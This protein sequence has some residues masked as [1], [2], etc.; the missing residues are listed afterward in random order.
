MNQ[1][2]QRVEVDTPFTDI[3]RLA[4][5]LA[6][7]DRVSVAERIGAQGIEDRQGGEMQDTC[8]VSE[9]ILCTPLA[10]IGVG[11]IDIALVNSAVRTGP[12]V[13][14][15]V[16]ADG[17]CVMEDIVRMDTQRETVYTVAAV[18]VLQNPSV[19]TRYGDRIGVASEYACFDIRV[20]PE[21][22]R[23]LHVD[24]RLGVTC[25][26]ARPYLQMK[27]DDT[28]TSADRRHCVAV[29]AR[30]L[31]VSLR[32]RCAVEG[33]YHGR[34]SGANRIVEMRLIRTVE[35]HVQ[36]MENTIGREGDNERITIGE[37]SRVFVFRR[38]VLSY[39]PVCP[40]MGKCRIDRRASVHR[41]AVKI[42]RPYGE[43]DTDHTIATEDRRQGVAVDAR[44]IE[45]V[46]ALA[47]IRP[48][49]FPLVR[50]LAIHYGCPTINGVDAVTNYETQLNNTVT[51]VSCLQRVHICARSLEVTLFGGIVLGLKMMLV[52]LYRIAVTDRIPNDT[53]VFLME[54]D[55]EVIHAVETM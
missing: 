14:Q 21:I 12:R 13:R 1:R 34:V 16:S 8:T 41:V 45:R 37:D 3:P 53:E 43:I 36:L 5:L 10:R 30:L 38:S 28:V 39:E 29:D 47:S 32:Q 18:Y 25:R 11:V 50:Q 31:I 2:C 24:I 35:E 17:D 48:C 7:Q 6:E 22:R 40:L 15:L 19:V 54:I 52:K 33:R 27:R 44:G 23:V 9:T 26:E 20:R 42:R 46:D 55:I 51:T 49:M 4:V